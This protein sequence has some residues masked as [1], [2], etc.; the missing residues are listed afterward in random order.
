MKKILQ[1]ITIALMVVG[2]YE[3]TA[4]AYLTT[5]AAATERFAIVKQDN[6]F[7]MMEATSLEICKLFNELFLVHY[8][9]KKYGLAERIIDFDGN[10]SKDS[11]M[12]ERW[13]QATDGMA[14]FFKKLI[15]YLK[16]IKKL[17]TSKEKT[18]KIEEIYLDSMAIFDRVR[19]EGIISD[20]EG[21]GYILHSLR[22]SLSKVGEVELI[23]K[24]AK[25]L[26]LLQNELEKCSRKSDEKYITSENAGYLAEMY[27]EL[28]RRIRKLVTDYTLSKLSD[29]DVSHLRS[30][31]SEFLKGRSP[32]SYDDT[33]LSFPA[34][35]PETGSMES[36]GNPNSSL[37]V[38]YSE[39][40]Q[41]ADYA[42]DD[43]GEMISFPAEIVA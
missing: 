5:S 31:Y 36:Y 34:D 27:G 41:P 29:E 10:I 38:D 39:K 24:I 20:E 3:L 28:S 14:K 21:P 30:K 33:D 25:Y 37:P 16:K 11:V 6:V 26:T 43:P 8:N 23:F 19:E 1:N 32:Q 12:K 18:E 13:K 40:S 2:M 35:Y 17:K 4:G 7:I 42:R 9:L 15:S 22:M